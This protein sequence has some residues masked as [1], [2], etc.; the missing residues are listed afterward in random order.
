MSLCLGFYS[1]NSTCFGLSMTIIRSHLTAWVAVGI[2]ISDGLCSVASGGQSGVVGL[3][4]KTNKR[5]D[6]LTDNGY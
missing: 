4:T 3:H 6:L 5:S 1:R 2:T